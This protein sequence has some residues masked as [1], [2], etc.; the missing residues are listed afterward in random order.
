MPI[1]GPKF[2]QVMIRTAR[3][4]EGGRKTTV[5][6]A[7]EVAKTEHLKIMRPDSGGDLRLS[8]V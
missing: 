4:V 6:K 1:V 3:A 2:G 7:A 8:G 5:A